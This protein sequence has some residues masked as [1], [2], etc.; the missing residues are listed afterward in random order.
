[1]LIVMHELY[2]VKAGRAIDVI[3]K[4]AGRLGVKEKGGGGSRGGVPEQYCLRQ[5]QS[6]RWTQTAPPQAD[7]RRSQWQP[8]WLPSCAQAP[9]HAAPTTPDKSPALCADPIEFLKLENIIEKQVKNPNKELRTLLQGRCLLWWR[10]IGPSAIPG[11]HM[12]RTQDCSKEL[13]SRLNTHCREDVFSG[14]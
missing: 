4:G 1:M 5:W 10:T 3:N 2:S 6:G 9:C 8:C 13:W 11:I 12:G 14:G 7:R